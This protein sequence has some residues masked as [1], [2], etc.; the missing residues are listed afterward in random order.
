MNTA[1]LDLVK[2]YAA[3]LTSVS[4]DDYLPA[5]VQADVVN[6]ARTVADVGAVLTVPRGHNGACDIEVFDRANQPIAFVVVDHRGHVEALPPLE[7]APTDLSDEETGSMTIADMPVGPEMYR[8][9]VLRDTTALERA[10]ASRLAATRA[11]VTV[12]YRDR[13]TTARRVEPLQNG[14][15]RA[16]L[17]SGISVLYETDPTDDPTAV[18]RTA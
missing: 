17:P 4:T 2:Q 15:W 9:R 11:D 1:V 8:E 5:G 13:A 16:D 3:T 12:Y 6:I 14:F 18:Q 10:D 7:V